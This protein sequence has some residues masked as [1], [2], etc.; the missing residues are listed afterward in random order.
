M[1]DVQLQA[2]ASEGQEGDGE[3]P[4]ASVCK[5]R[6]MGYLVRRDASTGCSEDALYQ[7]LQINVGWRLTVARGG[8]VWQSLGK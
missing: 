5:P 8:C 2:G 1:E 3:A 6:G 7:G 4:T